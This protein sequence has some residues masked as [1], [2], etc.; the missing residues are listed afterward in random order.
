[1][2]RPSATR[3]LACALLAACLAGP[4]LALP[5]RAAEAAAD[6]ALIALVAPEYD[7]LDAVTAEL[8]CSLRLTAFAAPVAFM[9]S[10]EAELLPCHVL[11]FT[12]TAADPV[13]VSSY[14]DL[15]VCLLATAPPQLFP[16]LS[17]V[18]ARPSGTSFLM[19]LASWRGSP[20]QNAPG[21][22][23]KVVTRLA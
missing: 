6:E 15:V 9:A 4:A 22:P 7:T 1:M 13:W 16:Y 11:D 3:F 21:R 10:L 12:P 23:P 17:G 20:V 18:S 5:S 2:N 14:Q 8:A 19:G